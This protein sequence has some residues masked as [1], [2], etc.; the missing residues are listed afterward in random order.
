MAA[1]KIQSLEVAVSSGVP[2]I[3]LRS[4]IVDD[5][6][7]REFQTAL[8]ELAV[9]ATASIVVHLGDVRFVDS[10]FFDSL[11]TTEKRLRVQKRRIILCQMQTDVRNVVRVTGINRFI[12]C[13]DSFSEALDEAVAMST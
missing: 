10:R 6:A 11:V 3:H 12:A 7:L 9:S 8:D 13:R 5:E 4:E 2:V 1:D